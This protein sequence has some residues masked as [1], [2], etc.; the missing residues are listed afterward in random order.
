MIVMPN[1]DRKFWDIEYRVM[2]II[3][4]YQKTGSVVVDLN[5]EGICARSSGLY[6][7][8]DNICE[9]FSIPKKQI[10]IQTCNQ[11]EHHLEYIIKRFPPLYIKETQTFITQNQSLFQDKTF[12]QDFKLFGLF[13]GR[14][15]SIRLRLA[16]IVYNL[17]RDQSLLTFHYD[18]QVDYHRDHLGFDDLFKIPHQDVGLDYAL[19][20]I[21]SSPIKLMEIEESYPILSPAH[22]NISKVYHN[23]LI[24]VVCET[25]ISGNTFYPT[26]KIW[27]PIVMKTPFIVQGPENYYKNLRKLGFKTFHDYWDEGFGEDPYEYQPDCIIDIL[28][29]LSAKTLAQLKEMHDHM[30]PIL[31]HNFNRFMELE[32]SEFAKLFYG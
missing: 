6:D 4:E 30:R 14:S 10:T 7:L 27:R 18:H 29:Q 21:K 19:N 31:E 2:D 22:L 8:L 23:F 13:I 9:K 17:Y 26:E 20:L 12:D 3:S 16:A 28:G 32:K 24:E 5:Q 25:Y 15:N 11:V 1:I